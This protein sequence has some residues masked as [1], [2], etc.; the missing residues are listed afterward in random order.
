MNYLPRMLAR[1]LP[2]LAWTLSQT[3]HGAD[4]TTHRVEPA[5]HSAA[6]GSTGACAPAREYIRILQSHRYTDL[7]ALFAVD[8]VFLTPQGKI[9]HGKQQIAEFYTQ[10]IA[11]RRPTVR[12]GSFI[13]QANEC[14]MEL[15]LKAQFATD[16]HVEL[17]EQGNLKLIP[18]G[19]ST[20]GRFVSAAFDHFTVDASGKITRLAVYAAPSS[21]WGGE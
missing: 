6:S 2:C 20:P 15:K 10:V 4:P 13:E 19:D 17:D 21:Y 3:A 9:L 5:A 12:S 1:V 16:G 7:A 11:A 18:D 8:A 14:A